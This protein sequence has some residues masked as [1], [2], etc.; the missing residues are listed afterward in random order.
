[1]RFPGRGRDPD[2]RVDF[3]AE[4]LALC[5]A[6]S[7]TPYRL[8]ISDALIGPAAREAA[9]QGRVDVV[10]MPNTTRTTG[11]LR[12]VKMPLTRGLLG[13]RLLL[14]R[15]EDAP[16][17][18]EVATID[19]LKR[20]FRVGYGRNWLDRDEMQALGFRMELVDTYTA[21]FDG[22][23]A[24]RFD[25]VSRGVSEVSN[26]L[27]DPRLAGS[28]LAI[29]PGI[30]LSY[31]LD[32]YFWVHPRNARLAADIEA[33][34]RRALADGSYAALFERFHLGA[35][36]AMRMH[37]R[38]VLHVVGYPVPPGTPLDQFDILQLTR[39]EGRLAEPAARR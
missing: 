1:V 13:V 30:A 10:L 32:D 23:R 39:S 24:G 4:L 15:P 31:P 12:P 5:L 9:V 19:Q 37:E 14:A 35:M 36:R 27:V 17:F 33:G 28:G 16:K 29:V 21:L 8:E 25:Y 38:T 3:A 11:G 6:R 20:D 7:P 18:A 22:L 2:R 34:C 26:E